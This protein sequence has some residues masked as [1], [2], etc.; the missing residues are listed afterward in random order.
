MKTRQKKLDNNSENRDKLNSD[1]DFEKRLF[2][3]SEMMDSSLG[4][5]NSHQEYQIQKGQGKQAGIVGAQNARMEKGSNAV[6]L[7]FT[8]L[9]QKG[10]SE[11][12][13]LQVAGMMNHYLQVKLGLNTQVYV[14][15]GDLNVQLESK[16]GPNETMV[17]FGMDKADL[18]TAYELM[19][20]SKQKET[21][22]ESLHED[23]NFG[24]AKNPEK[25]DSKGK[26]AL[27]SLTAIEALLED[28]K[29]K[30]SGTSDLEW[31]YFLALHGMYHNTGYR[32]SK[33]GLMAGIGASGGYF[34]K[35]NVS[36]SDALLVLEDVRR[37]KEVYGKNYPSEFQARSALEN[38]EIV[39]KKFKKRYG[40]TKSSPRFKVLSN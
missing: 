8:A 9:A 14:Y 7:V 13:R 18:L 39:K 17:I 25:S 21:I 4:I 12:K 24:T 1:R 27:I 5:Y 35:N 20:D 2:G 28:E 32:H 11:A 19:G 22:L 31:M 40:E 15:D 29:T 10:Y 34:F 16:L 6:Y 30:E 38:T 33:L 36:I 23:P 37:M 3:I 26:V